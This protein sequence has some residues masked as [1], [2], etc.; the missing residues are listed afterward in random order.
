MSL[1]TLAKICDRFSVFDRAGASIASAVLK[2][3][4]IIDGQNKE[5]IIDRRK[6]ERER[7]KERRHDQ[8]FQTPLSVQGLY[9][10]EKKRLHINPH[11]GHFTPNSGK[12]KYISEGLI[13]FCSSHD[14]DLDS[15]NVIGCDGTKTN[16]RAK[17]GVIAAIEKS[18][19]KPLQW[20][21]CLLH[22]TNF[23]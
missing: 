20:S 11:I 21:V 22:L 18:L 9:F 3:Y 6:V 4:G 7:E 12:A 14:L 16:T 1:H 23:L 13:E 17:G 8:S 5:L 10:D 15:I 19:G 2:D